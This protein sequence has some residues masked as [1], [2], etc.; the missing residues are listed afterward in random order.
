MGEWQSAFINTFVGLV[1]AGIGGLVTYLWQRRRATDKEVFSMLRGALDRPAFKGKYLWHSNHHAFQ[2]AIST[3]LKAVKT[4]KLHDRQG[5][6]IQGVEGKYRG[7]FV[8]RNVARRDALELVEDRLQRILKLS[9]EI[10]T[11]GNSDGKVENIDAARDEIIRVMNPVWRSF[12]LREMRLP[13]TVQV[14]EEMWDPVA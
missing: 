11:S 2:E 13:T 7:S 10:E 6:E 3:T 4:G 8:I 12:G 9:K 1:G 14:Y 5:T